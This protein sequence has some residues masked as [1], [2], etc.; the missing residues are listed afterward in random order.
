[1]SNIKTI[2]KQV[3]DIKKADGLSEWEKEFIKSIAERAEKYGDQLSISEKQAATIQKIFDQR[4]EGKDDR[5]SGKSESKSEA[6][7][8][9]V[10]DELP[11]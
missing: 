10:S 3:A 7:P 5:K 1:M 6:N 4:V 2:L 9:P 8:F 11:A